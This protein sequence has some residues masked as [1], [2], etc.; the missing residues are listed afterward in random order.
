MRFLVKFILIVMYAWVMFSTLPAFMI[1][2]F[3]AFAMAC[4]DYGFK[5]GIREVTRMW[6]DF[7]ENFRRRVKRTFELE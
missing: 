5:G 2:T 4:M 3:I 1:M 6:H 7:V